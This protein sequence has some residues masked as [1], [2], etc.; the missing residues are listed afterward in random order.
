MNMIVARL[1][2]VGSVRLS[3]TAMSDRKLSEMAKPC[4]NNPENRD[5]LCDMVLVWSS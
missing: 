2:A 1:E 4:G 3:V 5:L